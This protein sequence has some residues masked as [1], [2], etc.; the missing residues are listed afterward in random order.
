MA[1]MTFDSVFCAAETTRFSTFA[2]AVLQRDTA[3]VRWGQVRRVLVL[4]DEAAFLGRLESGYVRE[5]FAAVAE[6]AGETIRVGSDTNPGTA[7]A[8]AE[9]GLWGVDVIGRRRA[10]SHNERTKPIV[11]TFAE[12]TTNAIGGRFYLTDRYAVPTRGN[13]FV[14]LS[15]GTTVTISCSGTGPVPFRGFI[16]PPGCWI[17]SLTLASDTRNGWVTV[18]DLVMGKS[19]YRSASP[20]V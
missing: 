13:I 11:F 8:Y 10:L 14:E 2:T 15:D 3:A 1:T 4:P 7:I 17:T 12:G 9:S 5:T 18:G 16:A 20:I 19:G 6:R